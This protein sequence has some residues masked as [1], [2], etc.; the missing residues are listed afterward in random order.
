MNRKY[1]AIAVLLAL[2]C[3]GWGYQAMANGSGPYGPY[4]RSGPYGGFGPYQP[5][6]V[7][8]LPEGAVP[9]AERVVITRTARHHGRNGRVRVDRSVTVRQVRYGPWRPGA[10]AVRTVTVTRE[11]P[12]RSGGPRTV[13]YRSILSPEAVAERVAVGGRQAIWSEPA[14][15]GEWNE[16][17]ATPTPVAEGFTEPAPT[18]SPAYPNAWVDYNNPYR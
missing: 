16:L 17:R 5:E 14:A 13:V 15:V 12:I 11:R 6:M 4:G 10:F 3:T 7:S 9:I 2:G 18:V 8:G 1:Q